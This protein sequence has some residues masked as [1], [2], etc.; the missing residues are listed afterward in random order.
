MAIKPGEKIPS[1]TLKMLLHGRLQDVDTAAYFAKKRVVLFGVP[2][3]FTPVCSRKHLPGFIAR[4]DFILRKGIDEIICLSV[5]DPFVMKHWGEIMRAEGKVTMMPDGNGDFTKA[6]GL[7]ADATAL[8]F[9][10]R[11][12]RFLMI[13][14]DGVVEGLDIDVNPDNLELSS[15]EICIARIGNP[16]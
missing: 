4:S 12:Q 11:A 10:T 9:G 3:A 7:E 6:M 16:K 13:V 14:N 15:A 1:I 2:G 8:G 5:N